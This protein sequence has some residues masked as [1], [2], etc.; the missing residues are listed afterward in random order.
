M[1]GAAKAL[2]SI[3][4]LGLTLLATLRIKKK[5]D[6]TRVEFHPAPLVIGLFFTSS[7]CFKLTLTHF[8]ILKNIARFI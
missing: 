2:I 7:A 5:N 1:I 6:D 4:L 8:I 3:V